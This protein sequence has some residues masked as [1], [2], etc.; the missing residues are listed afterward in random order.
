MKLGATV[1]TEYGKKVIKTGN[2]YMQAN[3]TFSSDLFNVLS[4]SI[5]RNNNSKDYT[6]QVTDGAYTIVYKKVINW[7]GS[8]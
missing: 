1:Y 3:F 5:K 7:N 2:E 4:V 6:I 8:K